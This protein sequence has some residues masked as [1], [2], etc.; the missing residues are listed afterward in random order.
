MSVVLV[1][2]TIDTLRQISPGGARVP[3]Y[4]VI[5]STVT[6]EYNPERGEYAPKIGAEQLIFGRKYSKTKPPH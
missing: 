1:A 6:Y 2:L 3:S 5:N 4:D